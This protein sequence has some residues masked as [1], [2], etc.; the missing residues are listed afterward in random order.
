M[1]YL[2]FKWLHFVAL[3]SWMAGILYLY[4]ILVYL[5]EKWDEAPTYAQLLV[6]A[7]RLYKYISFP[8]MIATFVGGGGML[9]LNH[10]L[11][12][13]G[14]LHVKLTCVLGMVAAT[15]YAGRLVGRFERRDAGLPGSKRLR[16]LNE[17]PTLLMFVIVAMAVF[18][19]F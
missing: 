3:I 2:S 11:L 12:Q 4:R 9:S 10:G 14:W 15:L 18:R 17:I 8:A 13:Q 19:P 7:R 16:M 5:A 1:L 6:M